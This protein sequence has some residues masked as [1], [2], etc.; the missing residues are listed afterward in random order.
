MARLS[1]RVQREEFDWLRPQRSEAAM[2]RTAVQP[3]GKTRAAGA[4]EEIVSL[5]RDKISIFQM[6]CYDYVIRRLRSLSR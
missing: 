5:L 1:R 2:Q 4:G 6:L 3:G